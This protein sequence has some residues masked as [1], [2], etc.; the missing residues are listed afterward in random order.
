M[1]V[2]YNKQTKAKLM[3]YAKKHG[4]LIKPDNK[5]DKANRP[6]TQTNKNG[7]GGTA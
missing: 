1:T 6:P 4:I 2:K 3:A 7:K 5:Q